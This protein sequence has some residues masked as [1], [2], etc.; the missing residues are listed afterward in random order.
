MCG[1][2]RLAICFFGEGTAYEGAN[3]EDWVVV[4]A[5]VGWVVCLHVAICKFD[6]GTLGEAEK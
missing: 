3:V 6:S 4:V 2:K 1:R 5:R